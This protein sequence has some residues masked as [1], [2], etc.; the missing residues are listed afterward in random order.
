MMSDQVYS[1]LECAFAQ[2][3]QCDLGTSED[4]LA[5][6][7]NQARRAFAKPIRDKK[8]ELNG[9]LDSPHFDSKILG[10]TYFRKPDCDKTDGI[11]IDTKKTDSKKIDSKKTDSKKTDSKKT[12]SW[13]LACAALQADGAK[14]PAL[15]RFDMARHE[16][17]TLAGP[18]VVAG[19]GVHANMPV[20]LTLLPA[21]AN[22]GYVFVRKFAHPALRDAG[23]H[24]SHGSVGALDAHE[25]PRDLPV[26]IA[27][28]WN[29]VCDTQLCT[30][31][32][33]GED[34][35]RREASVATVEHLM[36]A[37]VGLRIDNVRIEIDG[38]EVPI[39]DGSSAAFIAAIDTVGV[40]GLRTPRRYLRI[41][42]P[43]RVDK[44]LSFAAFEP[45]NRMPDLPA[46]GAASSAAFRLDVEIDFGEEPIG[47]QRKILDMDPFTFR[48]DIARA[49]TFG[50]VKDLA[51][52][53]SKGL[54]RGASLENAI[55]IDD[56]RILNPEGLR[57]PDE[58]VRHKI[59]DAIGDL[60]LCGHAIIG[61][62]RSFRP[63]HAVNNAL[64][65][66]LFADKSNYEI[67][68]FDADDQS[69]LEDSADVRHGA[70]RAVAV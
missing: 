62:F 31:L 53:K 60:S 35:P 17:T 50:F 24:P 11:K 34:A 42:K 58:F 45:L 19:A 3:E 6:P 69:A 8:L 38:P 22:S 26:S 52:L 63:G 25:A 66:A 7:A 13:S 65:H 47:R 54:A 48:Y 30:V 44:G 41:I 5:L 67:V 68:T 49:R 27:A 18:V 36:A 40:V 39:M 55:G 64:L 20:R 10:K 28:R 59:L 14:R 29:H 21:P 56:N 46:S 70:C 33:L 43:V 12:D 1:G 57:Y 16:Q 4:A 9:T 32:G 15:T 37:L 61:A 23:A 51:F 2:K